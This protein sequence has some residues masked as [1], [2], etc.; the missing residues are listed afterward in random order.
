MV[1]Y[2]TVWYGR[3]RC[4]VAGPVGVMR[5]GGECDTMSPSGQF[6]IE[7]FTSVW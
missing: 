4:S 7:K 3:V 5:G 1:R 6:S 2:A